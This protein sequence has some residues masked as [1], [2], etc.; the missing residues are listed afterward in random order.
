MTRTY[1]YSYPKMNT[2]LKCIN[3]SRTNERNKYPDPGIKVNEI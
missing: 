3:T 1:Q 2:E